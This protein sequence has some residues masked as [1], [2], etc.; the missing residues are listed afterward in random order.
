MIIYKYQF[1]IKDELIIEMPQHS[2]ILFIGVQED[3]PCMWVRCDNSKP[4][5]KRY[6]N[7]YGTGH[8]IRWNQP[9][10]GTIQLNG[11]VWHIFG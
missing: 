7:V 6:F 10:Y 5:V 2:E 1:E 3:I 9:H 8:E 11:F 4:V